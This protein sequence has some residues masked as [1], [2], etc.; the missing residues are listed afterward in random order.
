MS[1]DLQ[2]GDLNQFYGTT[3]YHRGYMGVLYTDGVA[4]VCEN[5]YM[6]AI[7]DA[8]VILKMELSGHEFISLK[9][10]LN[11]KGGASMVYED[12]NGKQLYKQD[13]TYTDAKRELSLYYTG[14]VLMLSGEY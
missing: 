8:S 10:K 13:Y 7:T 11:D 4:Y 12:G 2:L 9:L 3:Q 6:W 5:G 14:G 1:D